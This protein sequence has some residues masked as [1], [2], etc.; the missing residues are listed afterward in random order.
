MTFVWVL[1]F[2]SVTAT[3]MS[4]VQ[5]LKHQFASEV[6]KAQGTCF[7]ISTLIT[8]NLRRTPLLEKDFQGK[9]SPASKY[10]LTVYKIYYTLSEATCSSKK[11]MIS[12]ALVVKNNTSN[13]SCTLIFVSEKFEKKGLS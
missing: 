11:I 4:C 1:Y 12:R 13:L 6:R 5:Q 3:V 10:I 9:K 7:M 8:S 2:I